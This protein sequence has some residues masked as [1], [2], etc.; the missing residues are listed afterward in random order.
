MDEYTGTIQTNF[1]VIYKSWFYFKHFVK[2]MIVFKIKKKKNLALNF[3]CTTYLWW[4]KYYI[5]ITCLV[6]WIYCSWLWNFSICKIVIIRVQVVY[7]MITF[8]K[9]IIMWNHFNYTTAPTN[10]G[11]NVSTPPLT[12]P[13]YF[14]PTLVTKQL[15]LP[16]STNIHVPLSQFH[17]Q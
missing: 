5:V 12:L 13:H 16:Q 7:N 1:I 15:Q 6:I 9:Y 14:S 10:T 17:L 2:L 3:Y 4:T 11:S 8:I